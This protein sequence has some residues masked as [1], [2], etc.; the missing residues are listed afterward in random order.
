MYL[1]WQSTHKQFKY[2][3]YHIKNTLSFNIWFEKKKSW[4]A[5]SRKLPHPSIHMLRQLNTGEFMHGEITKINTNT[6]NR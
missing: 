4:K 1:L 2:M 3:L 5:A 6:D